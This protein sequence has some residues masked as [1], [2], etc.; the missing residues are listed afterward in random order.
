MKIGRNDTCRCGSGK[1]YKKCCLTKNQQILLPEKDIK[2]V[3]DKEYSNLFGFNRELKGVVDD[4]FKK[5]CNA[6]TPKKAYTSFTL[7]K[8]YKTHEAVLILCSEGY[9]EDAAILVRSLF[10][11]LV[12]LQYILKDKTDYRINRY[13]AYDWVLRKKMF[14]YAKTKP[15]ILKEIEGRVISPQP[16][17]TNIE[18]VTKM[19]KEVQEKYK[20]K[21]FGWSDKTIYD[22]ALEIGRIGNYRTIYALQSQ[23][24]HTAVRVINEYVKDSG[25]GLNIMVGPGLNWIENNLVAVFDFYYSLIGECDKLFEFGFDKRLDDIAKRYLTTVEGLNKKT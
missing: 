25:L 11:L 7:G 5:K 2:I 10:E 22:M 19:A 16:G 3:I 20:Y 1:K 17:D 4:I 8:A 21:R 14:D 23:I 18:E 12:T 6:D 9:G 24:A 13:F 15:E